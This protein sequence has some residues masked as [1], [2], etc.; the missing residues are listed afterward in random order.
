MAVLCCVDLNDIPSFCGGVNAPGLNRQLRIACGE[1]VVS[2]DAAVGH[3]I[4]T[5]ITVRPA[6]VAVAA[7]PSATPPVVAVAAVPAGKFYTWNFAKEDQEF[8][9]ERDE[10]GLW[11]T[12]VKIFIPKMEAAKSDVLNNSTG[13][14]KITVVQDRNGRWRLIGSDTEGCTI[15]V[16]EQTNPKNG[17]VVEIMWES[18]HSPYFYEGGF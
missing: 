2:I 18:S 11:K 8:S 7:N 3:K 17:Y 9:S 12:A 13:D 6:V 15:K 5:K 1:D 16:K 4:T 14:D 10:N